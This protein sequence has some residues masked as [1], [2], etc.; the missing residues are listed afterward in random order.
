MKK[1]SILSSFIISIIIL[2]MLTSCD[3]RYSIN[4]KDFDEAM[5]YYQKDNYRITST[6]NVGG[7]YKSIY[8]RYEDTLKCTNYNNS[9]NDPTVYYLEVDDTKLPMIDSTCSFI[10]QTNYYNYLKYDDKSNTYYI[11]EIEGKEI[12]G[13]NFYKTN[14]IFS[15][16]LKFDNK[17]VVSF[18][19][20]IS[21]K[22]DDSNDI[23]KYLKFTNTIEYNVFNGIDGLMPEYYE[24]Y[25]TKNILKSDIKLNTKAESDKNIELNYSNYFYLF[26]VDDPELE[27]LS[28]KEI[29]EKYSDLD[30]RLNVSIKRIIN[31]K[32]KKYD[33][34]NSNF[35]ISEDTI[36]S[37]EDTLEY[38]I[39]DDFAKDFPNSFSISTKDL[40]MDYGSCFSISYKLS[41]STIDGNDIQLLRPLSTKEEN[42]SDYAKE[43]YLKAVDLVSY[44][45]VTN[46]L[47]NTISFNIYV[48]NNNIYVLPRINYNWG[49]SID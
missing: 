35:K 47:E 43:N 12:F 15:M 19:Y 2:F 14:G 38:L 10:F 34:S 30:Q 29:L 20:T 13:S 40:K 46:E 1:I 37:K 22:S 45:S 21:F 39:S 44:L 27:T 36:F 23:I 11:E 28:I 16:T 42:E 24:A 8:E 41:V 18:E 25:Y 32:T 48:E 4:P 6:K 49:I 5:K 31:V 26:N 33:E 7:T 17:K 3:N 9:S